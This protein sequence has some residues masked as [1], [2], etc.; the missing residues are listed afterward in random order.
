MTKPNKKILIGIGIFLIIGIVLIGGC[1]TE[2]KIY[3]EW[4]VHKEKTIGIIHNDEPVTARN[5]LLNCA[6]IKQPENNIR[7]KEWNYEKFIDDIPRFGNKTAVIEHCI[8]IESKEQSSD[9]EYRYYCSVSC[10]N[11][12]GHTGF[13]SSI[14]TSENCK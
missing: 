5:V 13:E 11:C 6:F 7:G 9:W 4:I 2:T 3:A 1:I 8:E 14:I 12:R 10:D